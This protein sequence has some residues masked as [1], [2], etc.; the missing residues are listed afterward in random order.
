M[1]NESEVS[2]EAPRSLTIATRQSALAM[3]QAEHVR[4][5]LAAL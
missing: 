3:W 1:P 4:V 5:R 2:I